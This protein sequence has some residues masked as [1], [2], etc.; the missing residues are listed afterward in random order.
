MQGLDYDQVT[1]LDLG[2][3]LHAPQ[4][5]GTLRITI[6]GVL[7]TVPDRIIKSKKGKGGIFPP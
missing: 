3:L 6:Y 7:N 4:F 1:K 5:C 2:G